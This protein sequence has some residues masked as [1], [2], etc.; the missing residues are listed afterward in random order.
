MR[1]IVVAVLAVSAVVACGSSEAKPRALRLISDSY[2][3]EISPDQAPPHAREPIMYQVR[4]TDRKTHQPID[5]GEGRIFASDSGGAKTWDGFAYSPE[6]GTYKA[7]LQFTVSGTWAMA[8]QFRRD[9]LHHLE[10]IDWMQDV[11]NERPSATP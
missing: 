10:R 7:K 9:S 5:N 2:L 6:V 11:L 3:Y 1:R 8:I 4:V